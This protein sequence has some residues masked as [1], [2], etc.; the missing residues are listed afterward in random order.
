MNKVDLEELG[1]LSGKPKTYLKVLFKTVSD[2]MNGRAPIKQLLDNRKSK[3]AT[4]TIDAQTHYKLLY[5]NTVKE[6]RDTADY[7]LSIR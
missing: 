2:L 6:V 3:E 1:H 4:K 7:V 5:D